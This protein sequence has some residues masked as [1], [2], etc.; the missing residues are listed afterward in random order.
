MSY[1]KRLDRTFRDALCLPLNKDTKYVIFSDCHRGTGNY[2]DNFLKNATNYSA[3]LQYYYQ[4]GYHYIEAGDGDELWEN[5]SLDEICEIHSGIFRQLS[6]FQQTNRLSLLYGNHDIIKKKPC[7]SFHNFTYKESIILQSH[8]PHIDFR[9]THG[10]QIDFMN[11]TLW[12]ISRFLVRHLWAPLEALG[13]KNPTS[14]AKNNYKKN[15]LEKRYLSYA[16]RQGCYILT[17]HTHN[18]ALCT[19]LSPY[20]NSGSCIHPNCITCIELKGYQINLVKWCIQ[21][22]SSGALNVGSAKCP[23]LFPLYVTREV[24]HSDTLSELPQSTSS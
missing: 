5:K 24:L 2:T 16:K 12:R 18:P 23:P 3:A 11:S 10:H 14:A 20:C 9:I 22:K 4:N 1:Q 21:A 8:S 6:C 13:L 19:V 7:F 15:R 17:G